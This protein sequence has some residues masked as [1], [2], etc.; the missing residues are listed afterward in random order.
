[1]ANKCQAKKKE[2]EAWLDTKE[3]YGQAMERF[4]QGN[5]HARKRE[6]DEA[7]A[8]FEDAAQSWESIASPTESENGKRAMNAA[9][10]AH[11][12]ANRAREYQQKRR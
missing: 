3:K 11:E 9:K 2:Y 12:A 6:W 4:N 1:M 7:I 8:A 10:K 5:A